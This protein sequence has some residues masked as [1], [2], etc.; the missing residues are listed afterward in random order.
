MVSG[1]ANSSINVWDLQNIDQKEDEDL[2]L[3]TLN[4][5]PART[6][7]KFGITDLHWFPFDNGIFTSSSFDHTLKVWDVSTLQVIKVEI[8]D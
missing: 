3:D 4:A 1:G 2:I 5:V 8:A 7:H 6:S